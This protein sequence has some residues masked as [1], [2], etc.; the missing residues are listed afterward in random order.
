MKK[1]IFFAV[2]IPYFVLLLLFFGLYLNYRSNYSLNLTEVTLKDA[3][4]ILKSDSVDIVER[5]ENYENRLKKKVINYEFG[6]FFYAWLLRSSGEEVAVSAI[7]AQ[8]DPDELQTNRDLFINKIKSNQP[9]G[10]YYEKSSTNYKFVIY[11][12][13]GQT[14]LVIACV[15]DIPKS[16]VPQAGGLSI[17]VLVLFVFLTVLGAF[18]SMWISKYIA[19]PWGKLMAYAAMVFNESAPPDSPEFKDSEL[20]GMVFFLDGIDSKKIVYVDEDRNNITHLHGM[21]FLEKDLFAN[22]EKKN[23]FAVCE[24]AVNFFVAYQNRYGNKKADNLIRFAAMCIESAC[25]EFG[26]QGQPVYHV[27]KS[28]FVFV[29][30][31]DKSLD[32]IKH[33]IKIFD[34]NVKI[35]YD[36]ADVEK[37]CIVSKDSDGKI[38][39]FPLT[40]LIAGIATNRYIPLIHP[41]QI[42]YIT[43][44]ILIYLSRRDYSCYMTDRRKE[45]RTPFTKAITSSKDETSEEENS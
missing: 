44:E 20:D 37:G 34:K 3:F 42:A 32:I 14:D 10:Y 24:V 22:I 7:K 21:S 4:N 16:S 35:F 36:E 12:A 38:G 2:F 26:I 33:A 13:L 1:K 5:Y 6:N 41:H 18:A 39:T 25:D 30:T 8:N 23:E 9:S 19:D 27:D 29:T 11:S 15:A 40:C 45:D 31:P 43:D 28:R 17:S